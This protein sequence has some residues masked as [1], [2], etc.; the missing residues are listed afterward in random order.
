MRFNRDRFTPW[1]SADSRRSTDCFSH[2]A[3]SI[4]KG[5]K[6]SVAE[7]A[8]SPSA[9]AP[10]N[11]GFLQNRVV[12]HHSYLKILRFPFLVKSKSFCQNDLLF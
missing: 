12:Y 7:G 5:G 9:T 8:L 1:F 6:V 10:V 2:W 4:C 3:I 11:P